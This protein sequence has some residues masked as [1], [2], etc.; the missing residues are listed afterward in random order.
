MAVTQNWL[1]R[2]VGTVSPEW[3][4][5]RLR[6]R[7]RTELALRHYE[8]ASVGRRTSGWNRFSGDVN[9]ANA[10]SLSRIRDT[11]RD[12]VRNNGPMRQ[13]LRTIGNHTVGWGIVASAPNERFMQAFNAW[14]NSTACDADGRDNLFGLQKLVM[15][16]T[17]EGGEML[18]RRR[19]RRLEDGLPLPVQLQVLEPDFLDTSKTQS[20][21]GGGQI[22][23]GVEFDALGRRVAYWLFP[24]HPGSSLS[25]TSTIFS[26]SRRIAASE[27]LHVFD[28]E[29]AGQVR[30]VS[31]F[32][33]LVLP[34]KDLDEYGDAQLM[35][36][37][38]AACLAVITSDVDGS[39]APL[40]TADDTS[41]P[42][43]DLLSPGAVINAPPGRSITV[44]DPPR[45][46]EYGAFMSVEQHKLAKGLGLS[47]E[48][49]TGDY[50]S[51]NFSSARM[52]RL[53]HYDNVH[54]WRWRLLIPQFCDPA[55]GWAAEAGRV[56]G[57]VDGPLAA[58]WTAPPIPMIEPDKEGLAIQR[59]IRTGIQTLFEAIRERGY[60]P[61]KFLQEVAAGNKLLDELKIVLD[62]DPR[63]ITQQGQAQAAASGTPRPATT[64]EED[65][66]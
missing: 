54:D 20:L 23:Q 3:Q 41:N 13:A 21:P 10:P 49:Y 50:S 6:A 58:E 33:A 28:R 51:V 56:L 26:A 43:I 57:L 55:F 65:D 12:L 53:E 8:A 2:A 5:R 25:S 16:G 9:A 19:F 7:L 52:S 14:A 39:A 29:R 17:A 40:G 34:A 46:G 62:S 48:D 59:N 22:I 1:D 47:Y 24:S 66:K 44:V 60:D 30:A 31:W 61:T 64:D 45:V 11:A 35:K 36:Q 4:L 42:G 38:I 18:I 37:K 15:R 63:K 32:A 27:I